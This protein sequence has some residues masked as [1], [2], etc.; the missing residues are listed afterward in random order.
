MSMGRPSLYRMLCGAAAVAA[1]LPGGAAAQENAAAYPSK[2]VTIII[3]Y[4]AGGPTD[5]DTRLYAQKLSEGLGKPFVIDYK[6]GAGSTIG[7]AYIAKAKPDGYI[8]GSVTSGLS[9][10][11]AL[12]SDLSFDTAKDIAGVSLMHRRSTMLLAHP[13]FPAKNWPEYVAYVKANPGKVNFGTSGAGGI[14]HMVGA[15][16]HNEIGGKVTYVH[17]KGAGPAPLDAVAGRVDVMPSTVYNGLP[18]VKAGKLRIIAVLSNT[19]SP[20]LPDVKTVAEQG[21]TDFDYSGWGGIITTGGTP[22]PILNKLSGEL[23]KIARMP[24]MLKRAAIDG[25]ELVG[26]TP[27]AFQKLLVTEIARWKKVAVENSIKLEE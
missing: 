25:T 26:S 24:D 14:Y 1:L 2:V 6:A 21:V 11:P 17:Y 5:G 15:W 12:Y 27:E 18:M 20:L 23:A 4:P 22:A 13:A 3:P 19:R 8:L 10:N 9:V 16:L 7:T